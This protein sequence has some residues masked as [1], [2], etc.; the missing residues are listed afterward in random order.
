MHTTDP[1]LHRVSIDEF[2]VATLRRAAREG[3]LFI[4]PSSLT[5]AQRHQQAVAELLSYVGRISHCASAPYAKAIG[6]IWQRIVEHPT[7][8]PLLFITRGRRMGEPNYCRITSL[9]AYMREHD[10]YRREEFTTVQLH[11]L[12]EQT[13]RRTNAYTGSATVYFTRDQ[14]RLLDAVIRE[15]GGNGE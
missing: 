13:T 7:V 9:V 3:R 11:L 15:T 2:D 6:R 1:S 8:S 14:Y 12:M 5:D 10:V 4:H